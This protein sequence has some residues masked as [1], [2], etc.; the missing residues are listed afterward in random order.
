MPTAVR[1]TIT[2]Q[3]DGRLEVVSPELRA[4]TV[5]EVIVLLPAEAAPPEPTI[6]DRLAALQRL[7]QRMNLSTEDVER[8]QQQARDERHAHRLPGDV[9]P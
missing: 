5:T 8:W 2:V 6:A 9:D 1:Q 7:Q 4:G 3:A